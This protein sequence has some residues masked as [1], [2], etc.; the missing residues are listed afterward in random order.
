MTTKTSA[1]AFSTLVQDFFGQR[2]LQQQNASHCTIASYRDTFRLLLSFFQKRQ[3]IA[4][5][6]LTLAD[7]DAPTILTF[8][9]YLEK[10]R[11]NAP[12]TRNRRLAALRSF[13]RYASARDPGYLAQAQRIMAIPSKRYAKP[14]LDY[15]NRE[16][17]KA[18]LEAPDAN[19]WSGQRDRVLFAV[20]YNTGARVS[21]AIRLRRADIDLT[22]QRAVHLL[23]KGRKER[24][25]PLWKS[26]TTQL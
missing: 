10:H 17:M 12:R 19:T 3:R 15:L 16:E 1:P 25:V 6:S 14:V 23:G 7:L 18:V 4:S 2:L 9:E 26:T 20:M 13:V 11:G 8:L 22:G 5:T 21:E 24:M